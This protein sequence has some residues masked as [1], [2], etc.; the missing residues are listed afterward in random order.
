[1]HKITT[2]AAIVALL[3]AAAQAGADVQLASRHIDPKNGFSLRPPAGTDRRK[4]FSPSELVMWNWRDPKTGAIAWSFTVRR[5]EA[6]RKGI[7]LPALINALKTERSAWKDYRL[8]SVEAAK[9]QERDA[10][11]LRA[12]RGGKALR[13]EYAVWVRADAARFLSLS[14]TGPLNERDKLEAICRAVAATLRLTDPKAAAEARKENLANGRA[15][16]AALTDDKL[17]P[18]AGDKPQWFLYRR[19]DKDIGFMCVRGQAARQGGARGL[20]VNTAAR[21]A[22]ADGQ[23]MIVHRLMFTTADRTKETWAESVEMRRAGRTVRRLSEK[24]GLAGGTITCKITRGGK[25]RTRQKALPPVTAQ[26]YLPRATA[27]LLGRLVDLSKPRA[28]AFATYTTEAHAFDLRTFSVSGPEQI[29]LGAR[30]VQAVRATD[31]VAADRP[32]AALWLQA[33]GALLR[34]RTSGGIIM[35]RSTREAVRRRFPEADS[36]ARG[37]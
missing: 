16:L 26:H 7:S 8:V 29:T 37:G 5:E 22:L 20:E 2:N 30:T 1:M 15:L 11:H 34:M 10:L 13:W 24:G 36:I 14:I 28:Y 18:A 32:P 3:A 27:L 35:E 31:Q 6:P 19:N 17:L 21:L 9:L 25:S 12:R 33:D 4:G 23:V